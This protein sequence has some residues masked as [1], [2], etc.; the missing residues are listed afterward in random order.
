MGGQGSGRPRKPTALKKPQGNPG[1]RRL[2]KHEPKLPL[3][4]P[5]MPDGL[6]AI[7]QA[8]WKAIVPLL[9]NMGVLTPADGKA[10]AAYCS[11]YALWMRAEQEIA[12]YGITEF[13]KVNPAVRV[14]SDALRQMKSFL[15]EFGLTPASRSKL[16][17]SNARDNVDPFE[18]FLEG[19]RESTKK[20]N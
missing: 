8:E 7:A 5:E 10:L 1:K 15:I 20:A 6:S 17:L 14:R 19:P 3:G 18:A 16:S 9:T 11:C 2:N 13:G 12:Q 4:I